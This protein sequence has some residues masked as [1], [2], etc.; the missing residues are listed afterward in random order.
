MSSHTQVEMAGPSFQEKGVENPQ[1]V[2]EQG[3]LWTQ[4]YMSEVF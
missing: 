3:E 2:P 4:R 1:A